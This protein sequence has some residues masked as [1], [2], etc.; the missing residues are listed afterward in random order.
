VTVR[1]I[2]TCGVAVLAL[3]GGLFLRGNASPGC[4]SEP[5]LHRVTDVLR[6]QFHLDGVFVNNVRTVSG[7]LFSDRRECSAEVAVIR[8]N[9]NASD[10]PWREI[11]YRIDRQAT[12]DDPAIT[13]TL[14]GD[15]P[16][17]K[18]VPSLWE[19]LLAYL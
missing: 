17:A 9:V 15:V 18:P 10:M 6:D 12:S 11:G 13:V 16:L 4:D 2:L 3:A 1:T 14:G 5:A 8:G 7:G 19:R